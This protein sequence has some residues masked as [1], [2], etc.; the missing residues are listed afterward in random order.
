MATKILCKCS[1]VCGGPDGE[2]K[3][4]AVSTVY[5]HKKADQDAAFTGNTLARAAAAM[6]QAPALLDSDNES[7]QP[8]PSTRH[9]LEERDD[10]EM[11][12]RDLDLGQDLGA[13]ELVRFLVRRPQRCDTDAC[14]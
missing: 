8:G 13:G 1:L 11:L 5:K 2:G 12:D 14:S 4:R 7:G 3:L 9:P 6:A 10:I